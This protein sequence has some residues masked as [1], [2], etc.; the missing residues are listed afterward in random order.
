[1]GANVVVTE[2]DPLKALEAVMDGYRVM[3]GHQAA[4][5][6]EVL[7]GPVRIEVV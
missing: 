6:G 1:M 5:I 2:I 4:E 7:P 3:T